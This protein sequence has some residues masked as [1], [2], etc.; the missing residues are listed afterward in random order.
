MKGG[1][2]ISEAVWLL[3]KFAPSKLELLGR[4][5]PPEIQPLLDPGGLAEISTGDPLLLARAKIAKEA[6]D[7]IAVQCDS[8]LQSA[9][10]RLRV[11]RS[12]RLVGE[13]AAV[14]GSASVLGSASS[15]TPGLLIPS[16]IVALIGSL[17]SAI[18]EFALRLPQEGSTSLFDTYA[19]L[20]EAR[21]QA[22]QLAKEIAIFL[23]LPQLNEP[24]QNELATLI[25]RANE[26][27]RDA[28]KL[29][30]L[31]LRGRS[32]NSGNNHKVI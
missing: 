9:E 13:I 17:S 2:P 26:L 29:L 31:L 8:G 16:G 27:C 6:L 7:Q 32:V 3:S 23:P 4:D 1:P 19:K 12:V 15:E 30:T 24:Q 11:S 18:S 28:V 10:N 22:T 21:F 14:V 20:G 25:G 5:M